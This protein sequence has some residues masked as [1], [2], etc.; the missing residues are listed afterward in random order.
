M[1]KDSDTGDTNEVSTSLIAHVDGE[2]DVVVKGILSD[3]EA[4]VLWPQPNN[5]LDL[6]VDND[7]PKSVDPKD[8]VVKTAP[9][10]PELDKAGH[11]T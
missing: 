4:S 9:D 11:S 3:E 1:V 8:V 10:D 7:A 5:T 2:D 6:H